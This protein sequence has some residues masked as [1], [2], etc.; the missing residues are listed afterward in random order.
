MPGEPEQSETRSH[1]EPPARTAPH[2]PGVAPR[3][4]R[5][6]VLRTGRMTGAQT[7][8]LQ[9]LWPRY[10]ID[11]ATNPLDLDAVYG[12]AAPRVLEI[13]F[14][15]GDTLLALAAGQP[16][17]DFLGMEV[18]PPGV[19][20][21]LIE[22]QTRALANIRVMR[23]DAVEALARQIA[24][25]SFDE[26]L[27]YFPDPWPKKRHHKRRLI[28]PPFVELLAS[29]L[30][31]GGVL[32]LATDWE[33]YAHYMLTVLDGCPRLV[34]CASAQ[35][36]QSSFVERPAMRPLTRFEKRGRR[37]GHG[38]WELAYGKTG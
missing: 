2:A 17:K 11:P 4:I 14:G 29:R 38:V 35:S 8:A 36:Q 23:H 5:S 6:F 21:L 10:G 32:R 7:R 19:G 20:H 26:I 3:P 27:I 34:N 12:R 1:G 31:T 28:Q 13:G 25:E 18:H 15:N 33:E 37:L 9:E 24:D 22:A 30:K 16:E